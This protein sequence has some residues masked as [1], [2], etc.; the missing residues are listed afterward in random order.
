MKRIVEC[1]PNFSE[2]RRPEVIDAIV[3]AIASVKGVHILDRESDAD[4]NR[5]V[6]TFVAPPESV[7][8]AAFEGIAAAARL[9]DMDVHQGAHP[10]MGATDVVPFIP[11]EGVDMND[12]VLLARQLGERVGNE[13][14]I[15][16]YLYEAAAT[17]PDR[18]NLA[19]VRRGQY[20]ALK[21]AIQTDANRAPDF[22]PQRVGKAGA[23]IIG[24]RAPLVAYN[25]YLNT[26]NVE[27]AKKIGKDIRHSSGGYRYVK[28]LG[29]LVNGKA[30][31]S[32]NLTDTSRTPIHRVVE[33]VRRE[34][35]RYGV[36]IESSELVGLVPQRALLDA[37]QWYLQLDDF[38]PEQVL[39]NRLSDA[40][41]SGGDSYSATFLDQLAA[42]TAAPGG[43]SAAAYGGAMG[44]ALVA[45]V[46]RLSV[47]KKKYA[48]VEARM[49]EIIQ[50]A[51]GLRAA[52]THGVQR[53][54]D[55]FEQVMAAF[56][57]PKE[58][59]EQKAARDAAVE[60]ATRYAAEVPL[61][62]ASLAVRVMELAAEV[63]EVG[64]TNAISDAGS[65]SALAYASMQAAALNVKINAASLQDQSVAA[66]WL[67][68]L[69][70]LNQ[71]ADAAA[72]RLKSALETRGGIK[73]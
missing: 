2:G 50:E 27:I 44:A 61:D 11:I 45:M 24:A 68:S 57:L 34:A 62:A 4:H 26:D 8:D 28:G 56:R 16:V 43:G 12:C 40:L 72:S 33:T 64:N 1:V 54:S 14:E 73:A 37:A 52:L 6:I 49:N 38:K 59:D 18:E 17:R 10:R 3:D 71:R 69:A 51:D 9:I 7:V 65:A 46:A 53:D 31:V 21:D 39:E 25:I 48:D 67:E 29:L 42:G 15:P 22:G 19:D 47:G 70:A 30:Q 32:M 63:A 55:A 13:L 35:A 66:P 36:M 20:E 60:N 41:A 5:S 23:V 58:T